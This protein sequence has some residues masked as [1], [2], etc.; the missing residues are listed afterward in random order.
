MKNNINYLKKQII[1]RCTHSGTKETDF[2][3]EKFIISK[4]NKLNKKDLES[5]IE[6]FDNFSDP[7]IH[8][9]LVNKKCVDK[10]YEKIFNK[11]VF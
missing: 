10:K 8:K 1:Y 9:I 2:L 4:I 11:L 7:Q 3:Y 5:I 6:I